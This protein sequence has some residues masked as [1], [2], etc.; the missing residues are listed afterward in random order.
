MNAPLGAKIGMALGFSALALFV[1][2]EVGN[3]VYDAEPGATHAPAE[4]SD[5]HATAEPS[6][7]EDPAPVDE[8]DTHGEEAVPAEEVVAEA[9]EDPAADA[10][11]EAGEDGVEAVADNA[12]G[13]A[14]EEV[15]ETM[16]EDVVAPVEEAVEEVVEEA[17]V[18]RF[19]A[20][21]LEAGKKVFK[22]CATCHTV[23]NGGANKIG[24]NLWDV[25]GQAKAGVEGFRYSGAL[26]GAGGTWTVADLDAFL[27]KPKVFM[28]GTKMSF[29][30]LKKEKDRTNAIA[31]LASLSD[32][33]QALE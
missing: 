18:S 27:T 5:S 33:P 9:H 29:A 22:K 31:Y 8:E 11:V 1:I 4:V 3:R 25:V 16:A 23:D 26:S 2:N 30:G 12:T 32:A 19:A 21:D 28:P 17:P 15:T 20:A 10:V 6:A 14:T 13:A 24:P 7:H